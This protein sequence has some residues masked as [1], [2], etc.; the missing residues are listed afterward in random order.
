[1]AQCTATA[2]ASGNQCQRLAIIGGTVCH[3]HGGSAPQVKAAARRRLLELLDPALAALTDVLMMRH[4][5]T[6]D[7]TKVA[8]VKLRAV[9]EVLDRL[10]IDE[11]KQIEVIT[12]DTIEREIARLEAELAEEAAIQEAVDNADLD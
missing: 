4:S 3:V 9:K 2:K 7:P 5:D 8:A 6:D 12:L 1:M 10:G 11:P